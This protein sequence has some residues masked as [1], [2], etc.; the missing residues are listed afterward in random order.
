MKKLTYIA[1]IGLI[2]SSCGD[3]PDDSIGRTFIVRSKT[4]S[5]DP[6]HKYWYIVRDCDLLGSYRICTDS[7]Y[8]IGDTLTIN[9]TK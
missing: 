4:F 9:L 7:V 3:I 5:K 6:S 8:D 1:I 2:F